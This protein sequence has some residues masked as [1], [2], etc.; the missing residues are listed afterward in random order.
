MV[1]QGL[2]PRGWATFYALV[3]SLSLSRRSS[4]TTSQALTF[5][6]RTG[7]D[8]LYLSTAANM[9]ADQG[10]SVVG[11]HDMAAL[12]DRLRSFE[13]AHQIAA[14]HARIGGLVLEFTN[15][16]LRA[17]CDFLLTIGDVLDLRRLGLLGSDEGFDGT[18]ASRKRADEAV[19]SRATTKREKATR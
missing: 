12:S 6:R 14:H 15:D 1:S 17:L 2:A 8:A 9:A 18:P 16:E 10:L 4:A 5:A 3:G 11:E 7:Y 13:D 19:A